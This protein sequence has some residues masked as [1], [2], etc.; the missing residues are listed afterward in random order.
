[1]EKD[2]E[3]SG[4][5]LT[6][7][8]SWYLPGGIEENHNK[9]YCCNFILPPEAQAALLSQIYSQGTDPK[10]NTFSEWYPTMHALLCRI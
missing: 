7:I 9:P 4:C 2:L 10:E 5:G 6:E 3:G 1:M 8:L